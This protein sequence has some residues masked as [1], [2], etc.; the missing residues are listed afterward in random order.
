MTCRQAVQRGCKK[1]GPT[2]IEPKGATEYFEYCGCAAPITE[3][4][5]RCLW[6]QTRGTLKMMREA[7]AR[8]FP[9]VEK[10]KQ[11]LSLSDRELLAAP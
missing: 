4:L 8:Y 2:M 11:S 1:F 6:K 5:G 3:C 9:A 10:C 7:E